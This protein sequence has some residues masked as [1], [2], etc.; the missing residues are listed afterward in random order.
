MIK[1]ELLRQRPLPLTLPEKENSYQWRM[2]VAA[3]QH[4]KPDLRSGETTVSLSMVSSA[5][6]IQ[7]DLSNNEL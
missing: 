3:K 5:L 2:A 7:R 6:F 4:E 1:R